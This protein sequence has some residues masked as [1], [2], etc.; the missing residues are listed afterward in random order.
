MASPITNVVGFDDAPFPASHRGNVRIFGAVCARTRLDGVI[1]GL[2]RR[3]GANATERM[4]ELVERSQFKSCVRA[5]ILQGIAVAGFNVVDIEALSSA[6]NVPVVVV[7]RRKPRL[8]LVHAAVLRTPGADRKWRLIQRAGAMEPL[9][10]L[11]VQRVGIGFDEAAAMLRATTLHGN[12]PEPLRLAHLIAGGV[13]TGVSRG[14][15]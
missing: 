6:L 15:A 4:I 11:W 5:V 13:T 2:V 9:D 10:R 1:S 3:D 14:R 7:A 12:L 8:H